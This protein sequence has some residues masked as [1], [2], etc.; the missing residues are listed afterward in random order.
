MTQL[1]K[2]KPNKT[3]VCLPIIWLLTLDTPTGDGRRKERKRARVERREVRK[4]LFFLCRFLPFQCLQYI[5][6]DLLWNRS[7]TKKI[8]KIK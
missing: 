6:K 5:G 7:M 1:S 8:N 2:T 3:S 4:K